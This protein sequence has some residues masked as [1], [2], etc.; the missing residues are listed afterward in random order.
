MAFIAFPLRVQGGSLKRCDEPEAIVAL[1]HAMA[2]SPHGSWKVC[3]HFGLKDWFADNSR[4]VSLRNVL[5]EI[6]LTLQDLGIT[7][8]RADTLTRDPSQQSGLDS[9]E[10]ALV[11]VEG[12][13][14]VT[15][16][17]KP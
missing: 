8:Y 13:Q 11:P 15:F 1:I 16:S 12:G 3:P 17:L 9:F 10:L 4:R 14:Y 2:R 5:V 6:N 7:H